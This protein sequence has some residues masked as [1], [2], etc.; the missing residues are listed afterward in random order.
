MIMY[1]KKS[2]APIFPNYFMINVIF[3]LDF[4]NEYVNISTVTKDICSYFLLMHKKK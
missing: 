3:I 1:I 2:F 4:K